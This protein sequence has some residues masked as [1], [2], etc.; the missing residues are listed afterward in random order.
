MRTT[1]AAIH[2]KLREEMAHLNLRYLLALALLHVVWSS[3]VFELKINSFHTA[4]RICRRH[5]D[6][7]IFFR[8][9]LKHPEDVI[10]AEPPCTFG[11]G[12]TNV[13]RADHTSISSSAPIRVPFHFKWPGTF[14]LIIEAWNAESP[15]EYTGGRLAIGEDWSQ[16]VHFGEQ[17]ELRYSYHVFCDEYYFGDGCAEYC[18][19]R[20]DT[21]GHYTCDEE[22]NRICLEGWKG[23]YCSEPIC[24]ADC[25]EKHGYC[26][27][28]GGC[29]CRMGWQGPSC[30]ACVRYPGCLHG[31][32]S[33]PWQCNWKFKCHSRSDLENDYSCTC[34]QGFY[35]KNCE[36]IAMTCADGPCFNG[37]TCVETMTG[38]YTC[39]CPPSYTGSNCEKKLDR[40]SNRPCLNVYND[41]DSINNTG[42]RESFLSPNGLFKISNGTA[43]LSL[44]LCPDGR[45]GYR[46]GPVE[47]SPARGE[48]PDF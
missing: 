7:H 2:L 45:S 42:E 11:T 39:R 14:S 46:P 35:G 19:P 18:R 25:S 23:N 24:S 37:G 38:G 4:Q 16:D 47:S 5:R 12:H 30:G 34:P 33:Q 22:G 17:S 21:L 43:R 3:G 36:I 1:N 15:T 29:T 8:I 44:A 13:I 6:C 10:S 31:T 28:P 32:C 27:A 41:L 9:C 20:D 26:E 48:R 40:C